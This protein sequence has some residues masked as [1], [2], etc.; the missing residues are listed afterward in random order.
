[1]S[2]LKV[3]SAV[4]V[5][6]NSPISIFP[7]TFTI[8]FRFLR[9]HL[10]EKL[11]FV[12]NNAL[13]FALLSTTLVIVLAYDYEKG[14]VSKGNPPKPCPGLYCGRTDLNESHYSG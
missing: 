11:T 6:F 7:N 13:R 12:M 9:F 4:V 14:P 1:M 2:M 10:C 5:E 3:W 8:L